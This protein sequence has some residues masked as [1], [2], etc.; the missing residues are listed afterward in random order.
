MQGKSITYTLPAYSDPNGDPITL[1][2]SYPSFVTLSGS[3]FT[4]SPST[5][6]LGGYSVTVSLSD[7]INA[8]Q[9]FPFT[10][11]V[12]ANSPP[13]FSSALVDQSA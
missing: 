1:S 3:T 7:G 5:G 12:T 10:I 9:N 2:A 6:Y 4:I 8:V 11:T 13:T